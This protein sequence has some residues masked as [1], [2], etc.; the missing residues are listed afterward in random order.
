MGL[1]AS[2][3]PIYW[4]KIA[5]P[6]MKK[7]QGLSVVFWCTPSLCHKF[8]VQLCSFLCTSAW[9]WS[10]M[11]HMLLLSCCNGVIAAHVGIYWFTW[12]LMLATAAATTSSQMP[13][14]LLKLGDDYSSKIKE[15]VSLFSIPLQAVFSSPG[16][17]SL[18]NSHFHLL[19]S[20][21]QVLLMALLMMIWFSSLWCVLRLNV[22][23]FI[24]SA[25]S[26]YYGSLIT[27]SF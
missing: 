13:W 6:G 9:I 26:S 1:S 12:W 25:G 24:S 5:S 3:W 27:T 2:H 4:I 19:L 18:M 7:Q 11:W 14:F 23:D 16:M 22:I 15:R 21:L 17:W 10:T 8:W 20:S